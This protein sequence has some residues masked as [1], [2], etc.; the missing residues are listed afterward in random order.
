MFGV[1]LRTNLPAGNEARLIEN[2]ILPE[3]FVGRS[4]R[5]FALLRGFVTNLGGSAAADDIMQDVAFRIF[6][7]MGQLREPKVFRA[8]AFRI[9]TR[10]AFEHLRRAKRWRDLEND[11]DLI[12]SLAST[13]PEEGELDA[14][15][16]SL[17]EHVSPAS[18]AVLL[19]HYQQHLSL[20][21]TAAILNVPVGTAKSRLAYGVAAVRKF[22]KEN[23]R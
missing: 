4:R 18:R 16:L 11:S 13:A 19:L 21:E 2:S 22:L 9:A 3:R 7:Q 10:V 20:E 8:W 6:R 17:I 1:H 23:K 14:D 5:V 12:R 15:F